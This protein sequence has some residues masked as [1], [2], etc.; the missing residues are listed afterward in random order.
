MVVELRRSVPDLMRAS[1]WVCMTAPCTSVF[2]P[3]YLKGVTVPG[4]LS[5]GSQA[6]SHDSPWWIFKKLQRHSERNYP[7]LGP[8]T[9]N[10]WKGAEKRMAAQRVAVERSV[11]RLIKEGKRKKAVEILQKFVNESSEAA[12]KQASELNEIL[13][14]V[15]KMVP[16]YVDL[17]E[18][19]FNRLNKEANIQI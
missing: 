13:Y 8:I 9:R 4:V 12:I 18:N 2:M 16:R 10:V 17:R 11:T 15:E 6:Y 5:V 19:Y 7:I 1:C 14:D 3:F